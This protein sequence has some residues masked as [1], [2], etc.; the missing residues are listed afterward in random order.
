MVSLDGVDRDVRAVEGS[1]NRESDVERRVADL[2]VVVGPHVVRGVVAS[3]EE[4][5]RLDLISHK[6]KHVLEDGRW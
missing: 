3:P 6:V 5:I 2:R 1:L 4:K